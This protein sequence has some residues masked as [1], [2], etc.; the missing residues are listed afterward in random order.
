MM[1]RSGGAGVHTVLGGFGWVGVGRGGGGDFGRDFELIGDLEHGAVIVVPAHARRARPR[2]RT[3]Q[4]RAVR[5]RAV[6]DAE[7]AARAR[8]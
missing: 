3:V 2:R 1:G 5:C 8:V 4:A 7:A 6:A